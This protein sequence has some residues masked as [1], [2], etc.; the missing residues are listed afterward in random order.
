[1]FALDQQRVVLY[2]HV[3]SNS[4]KTC[5]QFQSLKIIKF[6]PGVTVLVLITEELS[7]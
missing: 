5:S 1:M 7:Y 4:P 3:C 6:S 2:V